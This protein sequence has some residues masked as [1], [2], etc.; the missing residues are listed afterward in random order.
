MIAARASPLGLVG[1]ALV[2]GF[3]AVAVL[4]PV[5]APYAPADRAGAPYERPGPRHP[6]GTDDIGQDLFSTLLVGTR[7]SLA[8]GLGVAATATAAGALVGAAAAVL[9]GWAGQALLRLVDLV[10]V[11]PFLPLLIVL[12]SFL[13]RGL[14]TQVA[15]LAALAWARPARMVHARAR[16]VLAADYV[17]AAE[18]L[19]AGPRHVLVRHALP[20]VAP[21][22]IPL[23]LRTTSTAILLESSLAFL[24]LGDPQR[25]S[26]GTML[27]WANVRGVVLSDA[28]LWWVLPPGA[29][30][31][32]LVVGL[33]LA[34]TA[35]EERLDRADDGGA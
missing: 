17:Q 12:A 30:I 31:A 11:L 26:W 23:F 13:G 9:R 29:A 33:G 8:V 14:G 22:L 18:A 25:P 16:S 7:A 35:L 28:W 32:G 1:A 34:G 21:L 4:A 24:G 6:L 15:V 2:T 27:Y 5:L 10:L 19:G 3:L 20:E